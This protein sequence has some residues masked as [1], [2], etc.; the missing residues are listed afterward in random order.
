MAALCSHVCAHKGVK[1]GAIAE[2]NK[3]SDCLLPDATHALALLMHKA[4]PQSTWWRVRV[5]EE[6]MRG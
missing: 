6:A 5:C 4:R 2:G 1:D 3:T